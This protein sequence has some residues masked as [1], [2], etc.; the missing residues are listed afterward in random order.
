MNF[1]P[2]TMEPSLSCTRPL[3][4]HPDFSAGCSSTF[5][6]AH[7]H[8]K[9]P[10]ATEGET[11]TEGRGIFFGI[12]LVTFVLYLSERLVNPRPFLVMCGLV[13]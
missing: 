12:I 4:A 9:N 7:T 10:S 8:K 11:A 2:A 5:S 1:D 13:R 6:A 3:A